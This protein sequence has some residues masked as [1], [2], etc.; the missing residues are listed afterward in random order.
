MEA[1]GI[2]GLIVLWIVGI[3]VTIV[4][5]LER[6]GYVRVESYRKGDL[7]FGAFMMGFFWPVLLPLGTVVAVVVLP[8]WGMTRLAHKL[9]EDRHQKRRNA[10]T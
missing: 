2:I 9:V 4:L 1:L 5:V 3:V 10:A 6:N 8:F 7:M